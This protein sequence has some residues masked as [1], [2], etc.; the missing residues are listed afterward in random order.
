MSYYEYERNRDRVK[1]LDEILNDNAMEFGSGE[2]TEYDRDL[3]V[4]IWELGDY[5]NQ[6]PLHEVEGFREG[7]PIEEELAE[8]RLRSGAG[9]RFGFSETVRRERPSAAGRKLGRAV[10]IGL[11]GGKDR[12]K[13]PQAGSLRKKTNGRRRGIAA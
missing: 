9:R 13:S 7:P 8:K 5:E 6:E 3:D 2:D 11:G 1:P 10:S 12:A 4:M